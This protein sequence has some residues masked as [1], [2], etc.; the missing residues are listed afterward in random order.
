[1]FVLN[2]NSG[3]GISIIVINN[4]SGYA[5]TPK[6]RVH[7]L[8]FLGFRLGNPVFCRPSFVFFVPFL[9]HLIVFP[10]SNSNVP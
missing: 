5:Y 9:G 7:P 10:S 6:H 1:M 4:G 3:S 8:F 2:F